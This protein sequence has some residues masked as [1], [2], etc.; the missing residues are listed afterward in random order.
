MSINSPYCLRSGAIAVA[1]MAT[2]LSLAVTAPTTATGAAI[3]HCGTAH[4]PYAPPGFLYATRVSGRG[5]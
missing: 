4:N 3:H 1:V 5:F 2:V